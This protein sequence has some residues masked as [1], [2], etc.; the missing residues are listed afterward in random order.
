V[1]EPNLKKFPPIPPAPWNLSSIDGKQNISKPGRK[2]KQ[3]PSFKKFPG[4]RRK[5]FSQGS[6][7]NFI[8]SG[9]NPFP[10]MGVLGRYAPFSSVFCSILFCGGWVNTEFSMPLLTMP[11]FC[12]SKRGKISVRSFFKG[13]F[14]K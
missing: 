7:Q 2:V 11:C 1:G 12:G 4:R 13:L 3:P 14:W 9:K 10:A 8:F 6:L 5:K